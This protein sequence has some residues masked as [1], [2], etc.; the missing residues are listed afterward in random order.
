MIGGSL[1]LALRNNDKVGE[2]VGSSRSVAN[3]KQAVELGALDRYVENFE[4]EIA[5]SDI[6]IVATPVLATDSIFERIAKQPY[7]NAIVTDVGSVKREILN[8]ARQ[9]FSAEFT[10]FVGA[11]PIAGLENS[12]VAAAQSDLFKGK[13]T[14]ITPTKRSCPNAVEK[15]RAM[16]TSV[17]ATVSEMDCELHDHLVSASS[18]LPHLIAFGLVHYIAN[19][20][21]SQE[22]FDL[23]ASGFYDFTRIA[24]SDPVMWRDIG[25]TNADAIATEL[26]GYIA[27]LES[28][29]KTIECN[30]GAGLQKIMNSAKSARDKHL[31]RFKA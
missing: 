21:R 27:E 17:G 14:I 18:H 2:I 16:W 13:R 22:C 10:G 11:H 4:S 8:F 30:D 1:A 28:I 24:S 5:T 23:A 15:V 29:V 19:H 25:L 20:Q 12:G 7:H 6:V 31:A 9:H 3:L 26:R